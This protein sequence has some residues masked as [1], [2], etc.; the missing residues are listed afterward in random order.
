MRVQSKRNSASNAPRRVKPA[1]W[2][3]V[4]S[5]TRDWQQFLSSCCL[6]LL[7]MPSMDQDQRIGLRDHVAAASVYSER[8]GW[9]RRRSTVLRL[10][11]S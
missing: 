10:T 1:I 7:L 4:A 5:S 6:Q 2:M 3:Q 9:R 11:L 8:K